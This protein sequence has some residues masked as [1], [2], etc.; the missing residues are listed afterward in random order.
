MTHSEKVCSRLPLP[1]YFEGTLDFSELCN[2]MSKTML[3]KYCKDEII[4]SFQ[5]YDQGETG[6]ITFENLKSISKQLGEDIS[7]EELQ[8]TRSLLFLNKLTSFV[9]MY[10]FQEMFNGADLNKDGIVDFKEFASL[11]KRSPFT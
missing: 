10:L 1:L 6:G 8:V 9:I 4:K 3:A 11:M 7:D 5:L 2:L